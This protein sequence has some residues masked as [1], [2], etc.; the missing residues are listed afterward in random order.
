[1]LDLT[2][3]TGELAEVLQDADYPH[4]G[5]LSVVYEGSDSRGLLH[6][7]PTHEGKRSLWVAL[8]QCSYEC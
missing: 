3:D 2:T 7:V 8:P 5:Y 1:M 4:E 6:L